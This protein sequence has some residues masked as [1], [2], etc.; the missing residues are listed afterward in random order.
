M[1]FDIV[2]FIPN[3]THRCVRR[4]PFRLGYSAARSALALPSA[5]APVWRRAASGFQWGDYWARQFAKR[6]QACGL[7]SQQADGEN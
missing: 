3:L 4:D 1:Y 6:E 7:S 2:K 5:P